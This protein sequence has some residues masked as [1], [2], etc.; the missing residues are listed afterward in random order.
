L[1]SQIATTA[2]KSIK[3][4]KVRDGWQPSPTG[5]LRKLSRARR[6]VLPRC[7]IGLSREPDTAATTVPKYRNFFLA[8]SVNLASQMQAGYRFPAMSTPSVANGLS[9]YGNFCKI[10]VRSMDW[11]L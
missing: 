5:Q 6:P 1:K 2:P 4:L 7:A 9:S 3:S 10:S 8:S 11:L